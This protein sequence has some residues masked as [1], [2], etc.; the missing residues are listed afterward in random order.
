L[1]PD[2]TTEAVGAGGPLLG[3]IPEAEFADQQVELE[4][5][6]V[7]VL[8]TDGVTDA[9]A[10]EQMLDESDLLA[11]LADCRGLSAGEVSQRL[12]QVALAGDPSRAPRDDIAIVV[13]K[14]G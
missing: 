11:A 6:D 5:G 7:I 9:L 13:A 2:G 10:P 4:E 8:Y 12:E 1:R 14:L 3:V